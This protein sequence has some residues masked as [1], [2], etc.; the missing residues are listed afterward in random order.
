[1]LPKR[2]NDP[3]LEHN[4]RIGVPKECLVV[5]DAEPSQPQEGSFLKLLGQVTEFLPGPFSE[6]GWNGKSTRLGRETT[7]RCPFCYLINRS[8]SNT[9]EAY[10]RKLRSRCAR[11]MLFFQA[12]FV[13]TLS[14][15]H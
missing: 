14:A 1:M 13:S 10:V 2:C 4:G 7:S 15:S 8:H 12:P 6:F 3:S 5:A 11:C 9:G